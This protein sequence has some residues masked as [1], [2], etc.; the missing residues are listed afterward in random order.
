MTPPSNSG[1]NR[2]AKKS[3][4]L[5]EFLLVLA[6]LLLP[7]LGLEV[8]LRLKG[9]D[10][11][12][13]TQ[14]DPL[15]GWSYIPN[16]AYVHESA[17]ACPGWGAKGVI[18][19]R[20][21]RSE[22]FEVPKPPGTFRILAL[23]DSFTEAFQFDLERTWTELLEAKLGAAMPG[24]RVEVI[25]A[26]RSGMGTTH[27]WLFYKER[28]KEYGAD[29]V[30]VLFIPN[31]FQDNSKEL[32]L[33]TAYGPYLV[34]GKQGSF[35][36]DVSFLQSKDYRMRTRMTAIKR[37]SYVMSAGLDR[38]KAWKATQA[39]RKQMAIR[40][41]T[42]SSINVAMGEGLGVS[43][44]SDDFLWVEEPSAAWAEAAAVTAEALRSLDREAKSAGARL[45]VF[46][47]TS[48]IQVHPESIA[49]TLEAHPTWDLDRPV[50]LL[51]G[52]ADSAGFSFHDLVPAFR[53]AASPGDIDLHGCRENGGDGH[54]SERGNQLAAEEMARFLLESG[55]LASPPTNN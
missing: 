55:L 11:R 24:A 22:E 12:S 31:D 47:G 37:A 1:D 32:A 36:V 5:L 50:R 4:R 28:G 6:A 18:S 40:G 14:P 7:L 43:W 52:V 53:E 16:A 44:T 23:G 9:E 46:N 29:L 8:F 25:N 49:G 3:S 20:G 39:A 10:T 48:R 17:E 26:G 13:W 30:L 33:A 42:K 45:C 54:W 15:L 38:Y 41:E 19:S 34:P 2:S 21:L 27:E 51:K 35:E